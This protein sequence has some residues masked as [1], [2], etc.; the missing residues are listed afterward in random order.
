[1]SHQSLTQQFTVIQQVGTV[2]VVCNILD[3][4]KINA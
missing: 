2:Y 3:F 1:M 4:K